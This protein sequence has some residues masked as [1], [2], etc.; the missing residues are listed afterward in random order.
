M[1]VFQAKKVKWSENVPVDKL[2]NYHDGDEEKQDTILNAPVASR[3]A[4]TIM[5][6]TM[7]S[8]MAHSVEKKLI[9]IG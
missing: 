4:A 2:L 5:I 8:T 6:A 9:D 7:M 3:L 1:L